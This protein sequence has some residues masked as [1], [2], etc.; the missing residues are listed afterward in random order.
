MHPKG[1]TNNADSFRGLPVSLNLPRE[2]E[3]F[4]QAFDSILS[5]SAESVSSFFSPVCPP[6]FA[7]SA[8]I[9]LMRNPTRKAE[10]TVPL[11][12]A[13]DVSETDKAQDNRHEDERH[14]VPDLDGA[15]TLSE[16]DREGEDHA[17][18]RLHDRFRSDLPVDPQRKEEVSEQ[19]P[20][21]ADRIRVV[22]DPGRPPHVEVDERKVCAFPIL[23]RSERVGSSRPR[24]SAKIL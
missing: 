1:R 11:T 15:E 16:H 14:V 21:K 23:S 10:T 8:A 6:H 12:H 3:G 2:N 13:H 9:P 20:E 18:A 19:A 7:R 17:L 5:A 22:A 4:P 24:V